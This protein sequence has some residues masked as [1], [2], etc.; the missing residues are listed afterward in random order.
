MRYGLPSWRRVFA[1]IVPR[2][3]E[4]AVLTIAAPDAFSAAITAREK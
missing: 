3:R 4:R 1:V 2:E